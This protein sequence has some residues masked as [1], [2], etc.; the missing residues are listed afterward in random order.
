MACDA[1]GYERGGRIGRDQG[2]SRALDSIRTHHARSLEG[3]LEG[4]ANMQF[5]L[6][7]SIFQQSDAPSSSALHS[8][9]PST[10]HQK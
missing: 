7:A 1:L 5:S 2:T 4:V 9:L 6:H 3:V 8:E 10:S